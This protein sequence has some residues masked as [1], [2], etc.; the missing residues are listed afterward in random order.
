MNLSVYEMTDPCARA[1]R[2]GKINVIHWHLVDQQSFP[3]D[4]QKRPLLSQ[5]GAYSP[6]ERYTQADIGAIV[7]YARLRG[8]RVM[9]ELGML[10]LPL[11]LRDERHL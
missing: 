9:V 4:S 5:K 6:Q 11:I 7:E 1:G 10:S 2:Y 8:V 3:F